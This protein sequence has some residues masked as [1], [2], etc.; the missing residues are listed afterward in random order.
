MERKILTRDARYQKFEVLKT[1]RN[2]RHRHGEFLVEGVRN[3]NGAVGNGW[4]IRSFLYAL[5]APL[6]GWGQEMLRTVP[7][8]VNYALAPALM[9]ELSGKQ[10]TSE[11]M[12]VVAMRELPPRDIPLSDTPL[13]LLFDRP[14]NRGNLGTILRSCDALGADGLLFTGHGVDLYD[15]EVV[16]SSMGSFFRLPA[17][18][19]PDKAG[20]EEYLTLLRENYPGF[21]V[22]GTSAHAPL[23]LWE[24]NLSGPVLLMVG[25]ETEG[26]SR[27]L[28]ELCDRMVTIPMSGAS[29]ASSL[30]VGCA[31]TT[32][33][34]EAVRQRAGGR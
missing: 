31:A 15:S 6:S 8:E 23:S 13:L 26:L 29:Y 32:L 19:L 3:L 5:D 24:E 9:E 34:Y 4:E 33:L 12:A 2:K 16:V 20:L 25:N 28:A 14:S 21:A 30:N 11:L 10:E 22:V 7:T 17:C 1:N 27:G 18:F